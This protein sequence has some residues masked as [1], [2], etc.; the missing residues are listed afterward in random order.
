MSSLAAVRHSRQNWAK[1]RRQAASTTASEDPVRKTQSRA[2]I[3]TMT[4]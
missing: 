1:N 3:Q 4:R 2:V